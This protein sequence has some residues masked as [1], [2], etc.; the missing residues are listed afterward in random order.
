MRRSSSSSQSLRRPSTGLPRP[1]SFSKTLSK[2]SFQESNRSGSK[3]SVGTPTSGSPIHDDSKVSVG[4]PVG[5]QASKEPEPSPGTTSSNASPSRRVSIEAPPNTSGKRASS[6]SMPLTRRGSR[7]GSEAKRDSVQNNEA[8]TTQSASTSSQRTSMLRKHLSGKEDLEKKPRGT[9]SASLNLSS[10]LRSKSILVVVPGADDADEPR[11]EERN[12]SKNVSDD[13]ADDAGGVSPMDKQTLFERAVEILERTAQSR[14]KKDVDVLCEITKEAEFFRRHGSLARP[15]LEAAVLE[16]YDYGDLIIGD[17]DEEVTPLC[18]LLQGKVSVLLRTSPDDTAGSAETEQASRP[19]ADVGDDENAAAGNGKSRPTL[20]F[21][22]ADTE[23]RETDISKRSTLVGVPDGGESTKLTLFDTLGMLRRK[24][25]VQGWKKRQ[26]KSIRRPSTAAWN[27]LVAMDDKLEFVSELSE[28]ASFGEQS[29]ILGLPPQDGMKVVCE[30]PCS[31]LVV[32]PGTFDVAQVESLVR[33]SSLKIMYIGKILPGAQWLL[34]QP[35]GNWRLRIERGTRLLDFPAGHVFATQ[36]ELPTKE[37]AAPESEK[38]RTI[39]SLP[40]SKSMDL[41]APEKAS[42]SDSAPEAMLL[43]TGE[44]SLSYLAP[45]DSLPKSR[46]GEVLTN[47]MSGHII[48]GASVVA[49]SEEPFTVISRT[50][51]TV[52][53]ISQKLLQRLPKQ[54]MTDLRQ[55]VLQQIQWISSRAQEK[56]PIDDIW[57]ALYGHVTTLDQVGRIAGSSAVDVGSENRM[58]GPSVFAQSDFLRRKDA[59]VASCPLIEGL[60]ATLRD[61]PQR[62]LC[63][64]VHTGGSQK[65]MSTIRCWQTQS[66]TSERCENWQKYASRSLRRTAVRTSDAIGVICGVPVGNKERTEQNSFGKCKQ[67][68]HS[69]VGQV[70]LAPANNEKALEDK[71][72]VRPS[73]AGAVLNESSIAKASPQPIETIL[74]PEL[75]IARP[76]PKRPM[77]AVERQKRADFLTNLMEANPSVDSAKEGALGQMFQMQE[78]KRTFNSCRQ[79]IDMG[80]KLQQSRPSSAFSGREFGK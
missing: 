64:L 10:V 39:F 4:S 58:K 8:Q 19:E 56:L 69:A 70:G 75:Q 59:T 68:M 78:M 40:S 20:L 76:K 44:C 1:A 29:L 22:K 5:S 71:P 57:S 65:R 46:S 51:V 53:A 13:G 41:L 45:G 27:G 21:C 55:T 37:V 7:R 26:R 18:V 66:P 43:C 6:S 15:L 63:A 25:L 52:L 30:E 54:L 38:R 2:V 77:S 67:S 61:V 12:V 33:E 47:V 73:S 48:R 3:A 17:S 16:R 34:D 74:E 49:D 11:D 79:R 72:N 32:R 80:R 23:R 35:Q 24:T 28:G 42:K 50:A 9:L 31:L 14:S 36:G 62:D 60:Q